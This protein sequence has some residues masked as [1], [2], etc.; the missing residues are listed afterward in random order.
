LTRPTGVATGAVTTFVDRMS[1]ED[2]RREYR[3]L[4]DV[5]L[6]DVGI[7]TDGETLAGVSDE[8]QDYVIAHSFLEHCQ[9]PMKVP[10]AAVESHAEQLIKDDDSIHFHVFTE[11]ETIELFTLLKRRYGISDVVRAHRQQRLPRNGGRRR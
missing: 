2:L 3:E 4:A 6:V 7:V 11:F 9:D 10:E 5:A 8:S 1:T